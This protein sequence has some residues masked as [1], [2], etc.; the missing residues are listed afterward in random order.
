MTLTPV[1][2]IIATMKA[3]VN[4]IAKAGASVIRETLCYAGKL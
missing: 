4:D 1:L 3:P 2:A